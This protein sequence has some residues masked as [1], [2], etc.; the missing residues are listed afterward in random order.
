MAK[1]AF[2]ADKQKVELIQAMVRAWLER[3]KYLKLQKAAILMQAAERC[4]MCSAS[5][6]KEKMAC[7]RAQRL[8]KAW[9]ARRQYGRA[10]GASTAMQSAG[11]KE[12]LV[13][14]AL[15]NLVAHLDGYI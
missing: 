6:D 8:A 11:K 7:L 9:L 1:K 3:A 5:Y 12:A 2:L 4:L 15:G 14:I 13:V 10:I